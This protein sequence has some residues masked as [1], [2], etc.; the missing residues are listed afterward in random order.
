MTDVSSSFDDSFKSSATDFDSDSPAEELSVGSS[1][2]SAQ[3]S[4]SFDSYKS[5]GNDSDM[6]EID[7]GSSSVEASVDS[8]RKQ[9][10]VKTPRSSLRS[11][12]SKSRSSS[13]VKFALVSKSS[14]SF[15]IPIVFCVFCLLISFWRCRKR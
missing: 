14:L 15:E 4:Y 5:Y 2:S 6:M 10:R 1:D 9:A 7:D 8:P 12:N 13:T 3:Y 11:A